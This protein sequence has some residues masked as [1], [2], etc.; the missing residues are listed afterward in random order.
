MTDECN[1]RNKTLCTKCHKDNMWWRP[2]APGYGGQCTL[3]QLN[4][5]QIYFVLQRVP[6][7]ARDLLKITDDPKLVFMA[8]NTKLIVPDHEDSDISMRTINGNSLPYFK[9]FKGRI[10]GGF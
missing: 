6:N 10:G 8:H 1:T 5:D 3:D 9:L 7:A 4:I 2:G